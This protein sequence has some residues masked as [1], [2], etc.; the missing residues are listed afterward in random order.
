MKKSETHVA[1][2]ELQQ[3]GEKL[4]APLR[5]TPEQ[6]ET[7]A[8]G[9]MA[10]GATCGK[11]PGIASLTRATLYLCPLRSVIVSASP[12]SGLSGSRA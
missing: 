5:L 3:A 11:N 12:L 1:Q 9:L 6:L 7:I 4:E 2:G 10:S 8:A